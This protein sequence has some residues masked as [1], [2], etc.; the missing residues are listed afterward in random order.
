STS[1]FL[2]TSSAIWPRAVVVPS[3]HTAVIANAILLPGIDRLR[4]QRLG[5][6]FIQLQSKP[7]GIVDI[8]GLHV[9]WLSNTRVG[10]RVWSCRAAL[11]RGYTELPKPRNGGGYVWNLN[12]KVSDP[13]RRGFSRRLHLEE[14]F[15]AHL[16]IR[17]DALAIC[18]GE[19]EGDG[20]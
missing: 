6:E 12:V 13:R 9:G 19:G 16:V 7:L 4:R 14:R 8:S 20:K 15:L 1:T 5:N 18:T 10:R 2:N 17:R 11:R 3:R